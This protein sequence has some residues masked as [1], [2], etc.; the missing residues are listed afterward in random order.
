MGR[1]ARPGRGAWSQWGPELLPRHRSFLLWASDRTRFENTLLCC[2]KRFENYR[3]SLA[4]S[5]NKGG[6]VFLSFF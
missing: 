1:G 6:N 2:L 4:L 5:L 3:S